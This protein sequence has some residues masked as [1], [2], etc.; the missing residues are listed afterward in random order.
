MIERKVLDIC[1]ID[2][3][4]PEADDILFR[5]FLLLRF[6]SILWNPPSLLFIFHISEFSLSNLLSLSL[7]FSLSLYLS[8]TDNRFPPILLLDSPFA[9]PI[10]VLDSAPILILRAYCLFSNT[11]TQSEVDN[12]IIMDQLCSIQ[13]IPPSQQ[14]F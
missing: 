12:I 6:S 5:W 7:T 2:E 13:S 14:D 10:R 3:G 11:S 9:L 8:S 4:G 1:I